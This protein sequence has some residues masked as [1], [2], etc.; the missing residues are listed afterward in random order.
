MTAEVSVQTDEAEEDNEDAHTE[1][2]F[3]GETSLDLL[4]ASNSLARSISM[5][6]P[7][8]TSSPGSLVRRHSLT[9]IH[10]RAKQSSE[11]GTAT[12]EEESD[13]T[14]TE[15]DDVA[16]DE[17]AVEEALVVAI[18]ES[19]EPSTSASAVEPGGPALPEEGLSASVSLLLFAKPFFT[20]HVRANVVYATLF[21][22]LGAL[23]PPSQARTPRPPSSRLGC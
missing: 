22:D 7:S 6:L 21:S 2:E 23:R 15:Q 9:G 10:E 8:Q 1:V 13:A 14:A 12:S 19:T 3:Q 17:A 16:A 18:P 11:D 5:T 4:T 20:V